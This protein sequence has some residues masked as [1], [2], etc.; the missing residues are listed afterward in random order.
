MDVNVQRYPLDLTGNSPLNLVSDEQRLLQGDKDRLL[1]PHGGAFYFDT[2]SIYDIDNNK[3]L[4]KDQYRPALYFEEP[5]E[6]SNRPV[7]AGIVITDRE[8]SNN[9]R[10][11]Y[12]TVGGDYSSIAPAIIDAMDDLD[13]NERE[14]QWGKILGRPEFL[15]PESHLTDIVDIYGWEFLVNLM[16]KIHTALVVGDGASH[17]EIFN[18]LQNR[19]DKLNDYFDQVLAN[20]EDH[21]NDNND[22]HDV[23]KVQVGLGNVDN[24]AEATN[25]D[26][27][28]ESGVEN[29]FVT[30]ARL[31]WL[32]GQQWQPDYDAHLT[33]YT[34]PHNVTKAQVDLGNLNNYPIATN[35]L[36]ITGENDFTYIHP[37]G[38]R[39]AIAEQGGALVNQHIA[40]KENPHDVTKVQVGLGNVANYDVADEATAREGL[41]DSHYLTPYTLS[42]GID[43]L[44]GDALSSHTGN[45][46]NPHKVTKE[47]LGLGNVDNVSLAEMDA[48]FEESGEMGGVNL[49]GENRYYQ[50]EDI[51]LTITNFH[52]GSSYGI[53]TPVGDISVVNGV[54]TGN[55][56]KNSPL[57]DQPL[58]V[59]KDGKPRTV[60]LH[61]AF[62]GVE[63][64][65]ITW[66][67]VTGNMPRVPI[68]FDLRSTPFGV[69]PND[70]FD[71]HR[72]SVWQVA[73]DSNFSSRLID[74]LS[75]S[76]LTEK[77][78]KN[79]PSDTRLYARVK[80]AGYR[81]SD[82][83]WS[84]AFIIDT[85]RIAKPS[86]SASGRTSDGRITREFN[87][88]GSPYDGD[89]NHVRSQW[90]IRDA[91]DSIVY[92]V[93]STKDLTSHN[94]YNN[95]FRP[96][97]DVGLKLQVRYQS[98]GAGWSDWSD[99]YQ[100]QVMRRKVTQWTT[101][102]ETSRTTER[103][104]SYTTRFNTSRDT[105]V[106]MERNTSYTT[107]RSTNKESTWTTRWTTNFTTS[108]TAS[109]TTSKTTF[110]NRSTNYGSTT[111]FTTNWTTSKTTS[112]STSRR[113][114]RSTQYTSAYMQY[115]FTERQTDILRSTSKTTSRNTYSGGGGGG[116]ISLD[117]KVL[118][119]TGGSV[120]AGDLKVGDVLKGLDI[121]G[122]IDESQDNWRT[123]STEYLPETNFVDVT[124]KSIDRDW[125]RAGYLI[126]DTLT[127]TKQH[128]VL[129]NKGDGWTWYDV[130]DV[131]LGDIMLDVDAQEVL[132]ESIV[133]VSGEFDT[134]S[135]DVEES[136]TYFAG[137]LLVHNIQKG[138]VEIKK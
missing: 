17:D 10:L 105:Q 62:S 135:I 82:S 75:K 56:L 81:V 76:D 102:R 79:M 23:T 40:D 129:A 45:F 98:D 120:S 53:E 96:G 125:F 119:A 84:D 18:M 24:F 127:I 29:K 52:V 71:S 85:M 110:F 103:M 57:G 15:P 116:C 74:Q 34:N 111:S 64:P 66:P 44:V 31:H 38:M 32:I 46:N 20:L 106:Y 138:G 73:T 91:S 70:S 7:Y 133:Y 72:H 108:W 63:K 49:D 78:L 25:S 131:E 67:Q 95:G 136:D 60:N 123:W 54:L 80:H 89:A 28:D 16:K 93:Q 50:A 55:V 4:N 39:F 107:D 33:D 126:N 51:D 61:I 94:P 104:S 1:T 137:G 130:R 8:V 114:T 68:D 35:A 11:T 124:I 86:V 27:A 37:L 42:V 132:V 97:S 88:V 26:M 83:P 112:R 59:Y 14:V 30:P 36:T 41:S 2:V 101:S 99:R 22:P 113:K 117:T 12:Q 19:L 13:L 87:M 48:A 100:L 3:P 92:D 77:S 109:R 90:R 115:T 69:I 9:V 128:E 5:T 21:K 134:V 65:S 122:V 43:T 118:L 58:T 6:R 47:Q 121:E